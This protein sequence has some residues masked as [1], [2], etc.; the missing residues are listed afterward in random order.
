MTLKDDPWFDEQAVI[1]RIKNL[2]LQLHTCRYNW[3]LEPMK[4]YFSKTLYQKELDGIAQDRTEMRMRYAER[5]AVLAGM[6]TAVETVPGEERL[7]CHLF[8]RFTPRVLQKDTE[9]DLMKAKETFFHEDWILCRHAGTKTPQPG[10]AF[11]VNCPN[12]G[13]PF[14]L[15]KSAKCPMCHSLISVPDF[16]WIVEEISGRVG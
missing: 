5:P 9:T 10:A 16:S 12:C 11:S 7:V 6:L 4:P 3:D 8:T 2:W 1:N 14:S 13:A 15:Y